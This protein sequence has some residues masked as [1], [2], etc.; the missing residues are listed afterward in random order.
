MNGDINLLAVGDVGPSREHPEEVFDLTRSA[1]RGADIT[2]GQLERCLTEH[3]VPQLYTLP[4]NKADP[5]VA[6][7]LGKAGFKVMS[8]ASNHTMDFGEQGLLDTIDNLTKNGIKVIGVG[9]NIEEARRPVIIDCK[10]TKI[11]FLAYCSVCPKGFDARDYKS[12]LAPIRAMTSYEQVDW[13]PGTPCR[14]VTRTD[15]DDLSAMAVDI[16]RLRPLVDVL[17]VS[18]HWGIHFV[19]SV[20]AMYQYEVGHAAIDAG[21]DLIVGHHAHILKGIEVYKGKVIFFSLCNF[22][23]DQDLQRVIQA[24]LPSRTFYRFEMDPEY[25]TYP[26]P[27]DSQKTMWVKC[28]IADKK[29]RQVAW[30]PLWINKFGQP[31]PLEQADPRS[32]EVYKY[33]KWLCS[34]QDMQ[35]KFSRDGDDIVVLT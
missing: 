35:T 6:T 7:A 27:R 21:A 22:N 17:V 26:F 5:R 14:I 1:L 3:D 18:M 34:D 28:T 25:K 15:V 32:D 10:G 31:E 20:V 2:F 13:Q 4:G 16:R 29:I 24:K 8:F 11:G 33:M 19:P 23:M 12:G 9:K 30:Q